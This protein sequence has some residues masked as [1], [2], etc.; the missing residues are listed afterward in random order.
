[1]TDIETLQKEIDQIKERNRRVEVNKAWETST[2]RRV[3]VAILTY[4]FM[5]LIFSTMQSTDPWKNAIIPTVGFILSTLSL[6]YLKKGWE[7]YIYKQ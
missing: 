7:K 5:V 2:F 4:F 3:L 6:S 1:M